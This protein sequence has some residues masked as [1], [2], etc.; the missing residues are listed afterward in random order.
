MAMRLYVNAHFNQQR[1]MK[2]YSFS[3]MYGAFLISILATNWHS[4]L[5]S[6]HQPMA[7]GKI[8]IWLILIVFPIYTIRCSI[9]EEFFKSL[10]KVTAIKWGRQISIDLWIGQFLSLYVIYWHTGSWLTV[11]L[12]LGPC[13]LFGNLATLLYFAI[14]YD[15]LVVAFS[16]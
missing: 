3:I 16:N 5:W 8:M 2:K 1:K 13:I 15:A 10:K 4:N 7:M 12:W 14:H 11:A 6:V 9:A